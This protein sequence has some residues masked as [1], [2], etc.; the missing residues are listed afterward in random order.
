ML[1]FG[2]W[3][4]G[5]AGVVLFLLV[6]RFWG[7]LVRVGRFACPP[8]G[9]AGFLGVIWFTAPWLGGAVNRLGVISFSI[10]GLGLLYFFSNPLP[11]WLVLAAFNG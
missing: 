2:G 6:S 4:V 9:V 8:L 1:G 11:V 7:W 5:F 10:Y 3:V